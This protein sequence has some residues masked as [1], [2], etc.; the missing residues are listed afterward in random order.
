[1][2]FTQLTT[3]C[4]RLLTEF[5]DRLT[6]LGRVLGREQLEEFIQV[7]DGGVNTTGQLKYIYS[8]IRDTEGTMSQRDMCFQMIEVLVKGRNREASQLHDKVYVLL[9]LI[10]S[11]LMQSFQPS[12]AETEEQVFCDTVNRILDLSKSFMLFNCMRDGPGLCPSWW[13]DWTYTYDQTQDFTLRAR[14]EELFRACGN[15]PWHLNIDSRHLDMPVLEVK[16][17]RLDVV[18]RK[19]IFG[20]DHLDAAALYLFLEGCIRSILMTIYLRSVRTSSVSADIPTRFRVLDISPA[21]A[22]L[23]QCLE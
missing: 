20:W 4:D 12:Y 1:M 14:Q 6:T 3:A 17:F 11:D 9:G 19:W 21:L 8:R 16:G 22:F 23:K 10:H 2:D 7:L 15:A 5:R 18:H 13:P